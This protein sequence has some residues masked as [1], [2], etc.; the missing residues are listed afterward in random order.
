M[1]DHFTIMADLIDHPS[2]PALSSSCPA[3]TGHLPHSL[4]YLDSLSGVEWGGFFLS[5]AIPLWVLSVYKNFFLHLWSHP[6]LP[7]DIT[8][9]ESVFRKSLHENVEVFLA[10]G[11]TEQHSLSYRYL[12][13]GTFCVPRYSISIRVWGIVSFISNRVL[14]QPSVR[15]TKVSSTLSLYII[16]MLELNDKTI[17]YVFIYHYCYK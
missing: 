12:W 9:C 11:R 5:S 8:Y 6:V 10:K 2:S 1:L 16:V 3:Q 7:S 14:P 4:K 13:T 15:W 17:N